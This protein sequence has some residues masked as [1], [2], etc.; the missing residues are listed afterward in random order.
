M[1]S[2]RF[3]I[4]R[5][6]EVDGKLVYL[7]LC[8]YAYQ[9]EGEPH[10]RISLLMFPNSV[11]FM[12]KNEVAGYT[13]FSKASVGEDGAVKCQNPVGFARVLDHIRTHLYVRFPDLSSHMYMSLFP[14]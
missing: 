12:S 2:Q 9:T 14:N 7:R 3:E 1:E 13:I 10:Y 5:G 4:Y 8:G 6:R 11:Y